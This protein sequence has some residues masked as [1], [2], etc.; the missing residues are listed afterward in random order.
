MSATTHELVA[1]AEA[2]HTRTV[3]TEFT[4]DDDDDDDEVVCVLLTAY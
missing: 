4:A 3:D 1:D 2:R